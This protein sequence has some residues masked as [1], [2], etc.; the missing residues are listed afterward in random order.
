MLK[1]TCELQDYSEPRKMSVRIHNHWNVGNL[2]EIE[3]NG[4]ERFSVNGDELIRAVN[5]CMN[6]NH[7]F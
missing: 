4:K 5:N 6:N 1:V 2:V 3:I 7:R